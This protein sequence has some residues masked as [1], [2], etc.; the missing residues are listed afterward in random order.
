MGGHSAAEARSGLKGPATGAKQGGFWKQKWTYGSVIECVGFSALRQTHL[1]LE[2]IDFFPSLQRGR[3]F[4]SKIDCHIEA[5]GSCV[6]AGVR[7]ANYVL[8]FLKDQHAHSSFIYGARVIVVMLGDS[9]CGRIFGTRLRKA[10]IAKVIS[11]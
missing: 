10:T 2:S 7:I 8:C 3:L 5:L 6:S 1:C 9:K 11:G 4:G